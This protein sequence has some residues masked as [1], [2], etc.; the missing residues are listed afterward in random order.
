MN[1][2]QGVAEPP[3][4]TLRHSEREKPLER[5]AKWISGSMGLALDRVF[6]SRAGNRFG[7]LVYHR[8]APDIH[9][10][11]RPFIN[12]SPG[13]FRG[14]L[15]ALLARGFTAWPL[16]RVLQ[17][18]RQRQ[19][20]PARTFV[21]TFDD[22]FESVYRHAWPILRDLDVPATIFIATAYLDAH[23]PFPFDPWGAAYQDRA[24]G[25]AYRPL[26]TDQCLEMKASG[27]VEIGAH[28]HTHRDLRGEP[29]AFGEDLERSIEVVRSR[30]GEAQIPFAFPYGRR[31]TGFAG[32]ELLAAARRAGVSCGLTTDAVLV[33]PSTDP[34]GWGRFN[35][36]AW[37]TGAT[38]A[39]KLDGWFSWAP[40]LQAWAYRHVGW[41]R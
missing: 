11:P 7:I 29:G 28:T 36:Y 41:T 32:D 19:P 14:Q 40:G 16:S 4:T 17:H 34:F 8:T 27:L 12:V 21:V 2:R 1:G 23:R 3:A 26:T 30:F 37:D 20:I 6:G 35:G 13:C 33:D 31:H 5:G 15:A 22:G 39:A 25:W 24:P 10:L 18:A 9:G 38:I